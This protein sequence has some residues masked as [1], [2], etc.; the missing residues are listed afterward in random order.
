[1]EYLV[2]RGDSLWSIAEEC[3]GDGQRWTEIAT[4][5]GIA[6]PNHILVGQILRL[7][8]FNHYRMPSGMLHATSHMASPPRRAI[9]TV[10]SVPAKAW[11]FFLADEVDPFRKKLVRKVII[12]DHGDPDVIARLTDP[13]TFGFLPRNP[14]STVSLGRHVL[15]RTDSTMISTSELPFGSPRFPGKRFWIDAA[16][17]EDAGGVIHDGQA[18]S[19]DLDRIAAKS[20]KSGNKSKFLEYLEDIRKK[21]IEMDRE[22]VIESSDGVPGAAVKGASAMALTRGLQF[23]QGVCIVLTV[24]RLEHAMKKSYRTH[25]SAPMVRQTMRE[26]GGWIGG[27]LGSM[28]PFVLKNGL[29]L[30][31]RWA[32]AM[33]DATIGGEAGVTF[34]IETGPGSLLTG[35]VGG[36]L[37]G[38]VGF[39]TMDRL[40]D[41]FI[42]TKKPDP[43]A[44]WLKNADIRR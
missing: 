15:G 32:A 1:M 23:I 5:N 25:S 7:P 11:L 27:A 43:K 39:V 21:S 37:G 42:K 24:V 16:K 8:I 33:A 35:L 14:S 38:V 17:V 22:A 3:S 26:G 40:A 20:G 44:D 6:N 12:P 10:S 34:G 4:L 9:T 18:I 19:R 28:S 13:E 36:I 41:M 31:A 29:R 2:K 30:G